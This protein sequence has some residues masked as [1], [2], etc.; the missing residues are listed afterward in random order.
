[1]IINKVDLSAFDNRYR[2]TLIN[3]LAGIKQAVLI[4]SKSKEGI[5]NL[6]IFNSLIQI[7]SNPPLWGFISRP[8]TVRRETLRNI[9][10]TQEYTINYVSSM[11]YKNAHQSSAK[12]DKAQSEFDYCGFKE[13]YVDGFNAPFVDEAIVKVGMKFVQKL[14]IAINAIILV[15]G[16]IETI[17]LND[18]LISEDG[19]VE[20]SKENALLCAGLDA[21]YDSKL[22]ERLE[23]ALPGEEPKS[24]IY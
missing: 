6:A 19:F 21:Y 14:D 11:F 4:G 16:S 8:D 2:A 24:L 1:M 20:L 9:L 17:E 13:Y 22:I 18:H 23:Y 3:S 5:S 10:E 15:I 12:Y 7:G